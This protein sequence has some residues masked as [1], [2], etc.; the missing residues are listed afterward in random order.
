[1][2]RLRPSVARKREQERSMLTAEKAGLYTAE[3]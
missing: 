2:K 3:V 1:M